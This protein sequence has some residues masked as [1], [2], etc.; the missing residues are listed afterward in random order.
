MIMRGK[1]TSEGCNL[2]VL[3]PWELLLCW[4]GFT[5]WRPW[6]VLVLGWNNI[7]NIVGISLKGYN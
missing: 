7:W 3:D 4:V 5:V 2:S 6:S 1:D